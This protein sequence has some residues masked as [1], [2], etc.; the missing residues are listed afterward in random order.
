MNL[1]LFILQYYS[2][3]YELNKLTLGDK[4]VLVAR[5]M[6]E[7]QDNGHADV[8]PW[9]ETKITAPDGLSRE[10]DVAAIADECAIVVLHRKWMNFDDALQLVDLV[11]FIKYVVVVFGK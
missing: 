8:R 11:N 10:V 6:K 3:D 5:I 9:S 7:L 2:F 4:Q 1:F